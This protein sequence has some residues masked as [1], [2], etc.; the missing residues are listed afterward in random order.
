[1]QIKNIP[2]A[3]PEEKFMVEQIEIGSGMKDRRVQH[4]SVYNGDDDYN[5]N[6]FNKTEQGSLNTT[7]YKSNYHNPVKIMMDKK[8]KR[9]VEEIEIAEGYIED[10]FMYPK[11]AHLKIV[12]NEEVYFVFIERINFVVKGTKVKVID[13]IVTT[14]Q[15][16]EPYFGGE[17]ISKEEE[18]SLDIVTIIEEEEKEETENEIKKEK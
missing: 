11:G 13:T 4:A 5:E 7:N 12:N 9:E 1:M 8:V 16:Y 6:L 14:T 15:P 17:E 2:R 18:H 3:L 10:V